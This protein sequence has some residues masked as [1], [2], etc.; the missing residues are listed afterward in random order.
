MEGF[1]SMMRS[2][3]LHRLSWDGRSKSKKDQ[4][5]NL[6]DP[7][8]CCDYPLFRRNMQRRRKK[9]DVAKIIAKYSSKGKRSSNIE[10][11][12][13]SPYRDNRLSLPGTSGGVHRQPSIQEQVQLA[14]EVKMEEL[15]AKFATYGRFSRH[16]I[17]IGHSNDPPRRLSSSNFREE[18]IF[19][20]SSADCAS[21]TERYNTFI[22]SAMN[23]GNGSTLN[24]IVDNEVEVKKKWWKMKLHSK[25][26]FAFWV[27]WRKRKVSNQV[28]K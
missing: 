6:D 24:R 9:S 22:R 21:T 8:N 1:T 27:Q 7:M 15:M 19:A 26:M 11:T 17:A 2:I 25:D 13:R 16:T 23:S 28:P 3:E 20:S 12:T 10:T 4:K 18:S 5:K 14:N